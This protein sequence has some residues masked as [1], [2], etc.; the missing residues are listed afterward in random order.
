MRAAFVSALTASL[1]ATTFLNPAAAAE[2]SMRLRSPQLAAGA[3][4][5][6]S[7][8][9]KGFGCEGGNTPPALQW[10]GTPASAKSLALTVYDPDAPTGSGWWHWVVIDMPTTIDHLPA[11][12]VRL[13]EQRNDYST[14]GYGGA[15][16]PAGD[17]AH[18]YVFTLYAIDVATLGAPA[19]A[20]PA[21]IGF[22]LHAHTL[23]KTSVTFT[24]GR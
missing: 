24:Y 11:T 5:P 2:N 12:G 8:V 6:Q 10:S 1:I 13:N 4:L 17:P 16:P 9:F 7:A 21:L 19:D 20:S 18:H 15:C 14:R 23:A 22:L 3:S